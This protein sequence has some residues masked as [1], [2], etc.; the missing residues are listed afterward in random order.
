MPLNLIKKYNDLLEL[1]AFNELQ[2]KNSLLSIFN[3]DFVNCDPIIFNKKKV[4]PTPVDGQDHM[5]RLF[6]HLTTVMENKVL[7]NR[8]YDNHIAIRLHWIKFHLLLR[9]NNTL[10]FSVKEPEG[11]RTY[12][13]DIEEKYVVVLEPLKN[14]NEYYLLTA[15]KLTGKDAKRD[16]I[17]SKYKKRRLDELV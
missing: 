4:T 5:D 6:F 8:V 17:L 3:R 7:R 10:R 16:K 13:Y 9:K 14:V 12:I 11:I 1:S 2:R 15:Y